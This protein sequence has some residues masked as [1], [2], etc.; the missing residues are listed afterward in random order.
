MKKLFSIFTAVALLFCFGATTVNAEVRELT[1]SEQK[2]IEKDSKNR[3]KELKKEGWRPLASTSTLEFQLVKYRKYL[4]Q[5]EDNRISIVG[6]A[7]SSNN[8][9]GR[10]NAMSAGIA[11]YAVRAKAQVIG[12]LKSVM[13]SD[14]NN[15]TKDEIDRFGA[16]YEAAVNVHISSLVKEHFVLIRDDKGGMNEYNV[17]MSLDETEAKQA[18]EQALREARQQ[19]EL[20]DLS[21]VVENFINEEVS[22]E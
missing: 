18:R 7:L 16:A 8:K 12:K 22:E 10:D 5:D 17:F 9:I 15:V 2:A 3:A 1:K 21:N 11:N 13:S 19:S 20:G 6:I 14:F 4:A